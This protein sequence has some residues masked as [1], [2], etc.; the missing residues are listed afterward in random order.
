MVDNIEIMDHFS[1]HKILSL[2]LTT[3]TALHDNNGSFFDFR[4]GDFLRIK[5]IIKEVNW[6][7]EFLNKNTIEIWDCLKFKLVQL[8][9]KYIPKR[10]KR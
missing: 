7:N 9:N 2:E 4:I 10:V 1:D 6:N 8:G 3:F 5:K